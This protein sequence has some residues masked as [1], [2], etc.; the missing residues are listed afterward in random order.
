MIPFGVGAFVGLKYFA[1][2]VLGLSPGYGVYVLIFAVDA[3]TYLAS[4]LAIASIR[5]LRAEE[6]R[7]ATAKD[8][9]RPERSGG[10]HSAF[11]IPLVRT[12]FPAVVMVTI[13]IG[14]LFSVGITFITE[15]LGATTVELAALV[16]C[17]GVGAAIG[18]GVSRL[19]PEGQY[20]RAARMGVF[21]QGTVIATMSLAS[22]YWIAVVAAAGFGGSTAL[23]LVSGMSVLQTRLFGIE[24]DLAFAVFHITIRVGLGLAAVAAGAANDILSSVEWPFVGNLQSERVVMFSAGVLVL[25]SSLFVQEWKVRPATLAGEAGEAGAPG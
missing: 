7:R 2:N 5:S 25:I 15:V 21:L 18:L 14:S 13:G 1:E 17:F 3:V 16:A 20:I 10:I 24:R 9:A 12:I 8:E 6:D 4:Y 11:R 19:L 22:H 23:T